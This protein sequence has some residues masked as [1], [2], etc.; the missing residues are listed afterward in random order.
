MRLRDRRGPGPRSISSPPPGA[1][2]TTPWRSGTEH[3]YRNA[4][5]TVLAPTGTIGLLMDC[6]TTGIEPDLAL[7]KTKKL[8]GGGTMSIVN[9]SVPR[10][11]RKL[12]YTEA[13][14]TDDHRLHRRQLSRGRGPHLR[15]EHMTGVR[16]RHGRA[17]DQLHGPHQDDGRG[18][19]VPLGSDLEDGEPSRERHGRG[20]RDRPTWRAG[21]SA[22]RPSPSTG[23][24]ARSRSRCRSPRRRREVGEPGSEGDRR[25]SA[26]SPALAQEAPQPDDQVP[27]CR[28]RG[29]H[30]RR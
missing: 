22:S 17:F 1:V 16:H 20:C 8:V 11:L 5:A 18:T 3:G 7:K 15:E 27:R 21:V 29:L 24:T 30:Q 6:D 12:G 19:A 2:G 14:V 26:G 4:Q 10:A 28:H 9:Q 23:T 25:S 13:Q